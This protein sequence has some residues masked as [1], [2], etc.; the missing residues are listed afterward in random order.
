MNEE[1]QRLSSKKA[2]IA[3]LLLGLIALAGLGI[4]VL[5]L[6]QRACSGG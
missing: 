1:D 5:V 6:S 3:A 2:V 4:F